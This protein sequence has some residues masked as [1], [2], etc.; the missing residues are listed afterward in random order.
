MP[1]FGLTDDLLPDYVETPERLAAKQK[2]QPP[3]QIPPV[4]PTPTVVAP[5]AKSEDTV[6]TDAKPK[7]PVDKPVDKPKD[8]PKDKSKPKPKSKQKDKKKDKS[9][10]KDKHSHH[11]KHKDKGKDKDKQSSHQTS[12][13]LTPVS[14]SSPPLDPLPKKPKVSDE[15]AARRAKEE[16]E[17]IARQTA[18]REKLAAQ[19][20]CQQDEEDR[21]ML[22]TDLMVVSPS[23][24]APP[25]EPVEAPVK[26][27]H[28]YRITKFVANDHE[29]VETLPDDDNDEDEDDEDDDEDEDDD[30]DEDGKD[31]ED[32]TLAVDDPDVE[33]N[34]FIPKQ[35]LPDETIPDNDNADSNDAASSSSAS[36]SAVESTPQRSI[37]YDGDAHLE[38]EPDENGYDDDDVD[39]TEDNDDGYAEDD[40][41]GAREKRD[42]LWARP[43]FC[44]GNTELGEKITFCKTKMQQDRGCRNSIVYAT[45]L[46]VLKIIDECPA[47]TPSIKAAARKYCDE[48][49]DRQYY[50]NYRKR[51]LREYR[52]YIARRKLRHH[53]ITPEVSELLTKYVDYER[54]VTDSD[55]NNTVHFETDAPSSPPSPE[56]YCE[57]L[58]CRA[59]M[60]MMARKNWPR[61]VASIISRYRDRLTNPANEERPLPLFGP[62]MEAIIKKRSSVSVIR[63]MRTLTSGR[64]LTNHVS[65]CY[66]HL[67]CVTGFFYPK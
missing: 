21:Q 6:M 67:Q 27:S 41:P 10:D 47:S 45:C 3:V 8:K 40:A 57:P 58:M 29:T 42:P 24:P 48:H 2:Q 14:T 36:T 33:D 5:Q 54:L 34:E 9:K 65:N 26:G 60:L 12:L 59:L 23:T 30:D 13:S 52:A 62:L 20:Q 46:A 55:N 31:E 66:L 49:G 44:D 1:T 64:A 63:A 11:H 50:V 37:G 32:V 18:S 17:C 56:F 51:E 19:L 53:H 28:G 22:I 43:S 16:A 38:F 15:E 61:T 25:P 7:E 4:T 39:D 35:Q